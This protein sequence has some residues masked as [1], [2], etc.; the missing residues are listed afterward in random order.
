MATLREY[1]K[2]VRYLSRREVSRERADLF[3]TLNGDAF[4]PIKLWPD[5]MRM[6]FWRKPI[7]DKDTFKL[8]LFCI[9]NGCSPNLISKMDS[10]QKRIVKAPEKARARLG[11]RQVDFVLKAMPTRKPEAAGCITT[12]ITGVNYYRACERPRQRAA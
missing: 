9:G 1:R 2:T 3:K 5:E 4:F 10:E 7:G 8:V 11:A 6:A 12:S